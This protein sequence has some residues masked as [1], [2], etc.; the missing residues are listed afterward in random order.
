MIIITRKILENI[1]TELVGLEFKQND[2]NN[3]SAALFDICLDHANAI[4]AL[5]EKK[6]P[7]I[8]SA[9]ALVRPMFESFIRA[10]WLQHCATDKQIKKI[11][12]KDS[13]PLSLREMLEAVEKEN[14]WPK[15]L[16]KIM[17]KAIKNMHSYTHGGMQLINRR[18]KGGVLAH[19]MDKKEI[20]DVATFI[21]LI[22]YVSFC[23]TVAIAGTTNKDT[24]IKSLYHDIITQY[25]S[26]K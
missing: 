10:A 7:I 18:F 26:S 6:K 2:R 25:L 16:T 13:F 4:V 23:Q 17:K 11:I 22:A 12:K 21:V 14:K 8:P 19:V 5:I 24:F 9:Y 15:T 3:L 1:E 20:N